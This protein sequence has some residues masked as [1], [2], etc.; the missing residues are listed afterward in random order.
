MH[1]QTMDP[2]NSYSVNQED[3]S[4]TFLQSQ[5][6]GLGV[7]PFFFVTAPLGHALYAT[8]PKLGLTEPCGFLFAWTIDFQTGLL[9]QVYDSQNDT[10]FGP[11]CFPGPPSFTPTNAYAYVANSGTGSLVNGLFG[12]AV[13]P[14]TGN[15]TNVPGTPVATQNQLAP[16]AVFVEPTQGKFVIELGSAFSNEFFSWAIDPA[17]GA[18]TQVSGVALPITQPNW[19]KAVIVAPPQPGP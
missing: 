18:L 19:Y 16:G 1:N 4:L 5:G 15:L 11:L 10:S 6:G 12:A 13:D 9:T 17:T 14:A 8:A 2:L 7:V 3:G